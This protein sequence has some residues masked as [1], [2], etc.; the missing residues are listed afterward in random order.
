MILNS[1]Y[2]IVVLISF[3]YSLYILIIK[4]KSKQQFYFFLYLLMVILIDILPVNLY[5]MITFNR[6]LLFTAYIIL[7]IIYFG[8]IYYRSIEGK[9]FRILN[10]VFSVTLIFFIF[11]KSQIKNVEKL[12][13]VSLISLPVFF[14]FLSI[15][16]YVFK[17]KNVNEKTIVSDFLFWI[18][19]AILIWS[20]VFIF[21]A[22]PMYFLQ[23]ND[24]GLLNFL[25]S[26]FSIVNIVTYSLFLIGLIFV[27]NE[28]TSRRI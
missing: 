9:I 27:S 5:R 20:V 10:L 16:W 15:S 2:E 8:L 11:Y 14:I 17:L 19:S 25:I 26:V 4:K 12:E 21:R 1:I 23:E 7:S 28:S 18:S 22:I 3:L 13:F 24:A 6:N